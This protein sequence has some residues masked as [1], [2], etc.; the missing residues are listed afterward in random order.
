[1]K[2]L[3][4][5]IDPAVARKLVDAAN[6]KTAYFKKH[7]EADAILRADTRMY[8]HTF[9]LNVN[10]STLRMFQ[11]KRFAVPLQVN[12]SMQFLTGG[13]DTPKYERYDFEFR[14]FF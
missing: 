14:M 4:A 5:L 2:V 10:Y 11:K 7:P 12:V 13:L 6:W 3:E 9:K 1:M 8:S